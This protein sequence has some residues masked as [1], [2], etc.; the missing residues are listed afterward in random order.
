M[1]VY[2]ESVRL[3]E[4]IAER[5]QFIMKYDFEIPVHDIIGRQQGINIELHSLSFFDNFYIIFTV[6]KAVSMRKIVQ[7]LDGRNW[8]ALDYFRMVENKNKFQTQNEIIPRHISVRILNSLTAYFLLF[9][10]LEI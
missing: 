10:S 9:H 1:T 2:S 6:T 5:R 4:K 7:H 3:A 8:R